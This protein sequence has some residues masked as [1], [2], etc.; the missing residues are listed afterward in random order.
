M[1]NLSLINKIKNS[2]CSKFQ[3]KVYIE[4]LNVKKGSVIS[5]SKL[6]EKIGRTGAA[7]AV[8]NAL[9]K[10]PFAPDVPCHR[11]VKNDGSIGG[12]AHGKDKKIAILLAEGIEIE[13]GKVVAL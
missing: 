11:V 7:R 10:N 5:Y 8:G 13:N 6:A 12:F 9:N 3:K 2:Q 4:L 1:S